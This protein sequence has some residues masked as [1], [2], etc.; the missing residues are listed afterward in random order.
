LKFQHEQ[1]GFPL[2]GMHGKAA[3]GVCHRDLRFSF[4]GSA[5]ADC[6]NDVHRGQFGDACQNCHSPQNW[7]NRRDNFELHASRGFPLVG[8]HA[9]TDCGA[10]HVGQERSEYAGT[11]QECRVCHQAD[12]AESTNPDHEL[13]GFSGDCQQCHQPVAASWRLTSFQHSGTFPMRGRHATAECISCHAT[14]FRGLTHICYDCHTQDFAATT[15]PNHTSFGFPTTCE[16]CHTDLGWDRAQFDHV[17]E[18]NGFALQGAHGTIQCIACHVDNQMENLPLDCF[19]C[20]QEDFAAVVDPSHTQGNFPQDCLICHNQNAWVPAT[21]DHSLSQFPLSGAHATTPCNS[22]HAAGYQ[23]TPTECYACHQADFEGAADPNHVQNNFDHNCATCHSTTAWQPA[24]FNHANTQFPLTG[25]HITTP[26][27]SCHAGG[28]AGTPT[29]CWSCHQGDYNGVTDPNHVQNN[30][31]HNCATCHST[32]AWEPATFNHNN[33]QFPLTGAHIS[34]ACNECHADGYDIPF[35]CWSCHEADYHD[36]ENH[37]ANGYPHDCTQCHNT[38]DWEGGEFNHGNT[39]FPLTGAHVALPCLTCHAGG[40]QDTPSECYACHQSDFDGVADP[41]HIQNNFDH[42]CLLCHGTAAWT[43]ATFDHNQSQFPLTGAHS[44]TPC[45]SC[46]ANG[47]DNT[48]TDCY[49]CH[50]ADFEGVTD[51]NHVQNNFDHNCAN[52]HS[53]TA[54]EPATFDHN[55][56]QFPL[57]GAHVN[58]NCNECHDV[59]YDISFDCWSCHE[60]DYHDAEGHDANGYPHD[61]TQCH[62]TTDWG[63]GEFNHGNTGFPLTGAH[64][65]LQCLACH[66]GGY[67]NTPPECY[68]CHQGD[69]E[70]VP[71]PNHVAD[72]FSHDCTG[73]HTTA[74]WLPATYDHNLSQFP[75]TGA[76][77]TVPC[78]SCHANGFDNTASDCFSCHQDDYNAVPDPNHVQNNFD[79]DCTVCHTTAAWSPSTFNH[80]NTQFPLT[81][82]HVTVPCLSCHAGGYDNTPIDCYACHQPD[83]EGVTDPNHVQGNYSHI[84]TDCHTTTGWSPATFDHNLTQF[85]L[86]GAHVNAPCAACHANGFENTPMEC[87]ACHQADYNNADPDHQTSGFPTTC[88]DCHNTAA[89]SPSSWNHDAQYFPIYSGRHEGRWSVCTDCHVNPGNFEVFECIFCHEHNQPDTDPRHT[90]VPG[91]QYNSQACYSC[92]PRGEADD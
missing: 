68:A 50:Q 87:Y 10:C 31:D 37:D 44:T 36:A 89:W 24:T 46:H 70:G 32:S 29:D 26:C 61:C 53:T 28:F 38:T 91:Y 14:Q 72:N 8:V 34:L 56:T 47:Y 6:H 2:V 42:N 16:G 58:L 85:P 65:G 41:S 7:A 80:A 45:L 54:W 23:G 30:F 43:P 15:D 40:Y 39:G 90:G 81:G 83:F 13:A 12:F 48:P 52:C 51:P 82:A 59:G 73:C 69:F 27:L 21:F 5:C 63:S 57:T 66:A 67:Q 25:A 71:D 78:A 84:C 20:H 19:G 22:C 11:S 33:T 79:H 64:V 74:A 9:I 17:A 92:H 49:A 88:Q 3:C 60:A 1:T 86:T 75:L 77:T 55:N 35:D 4:V 76:H 18:G 62:N